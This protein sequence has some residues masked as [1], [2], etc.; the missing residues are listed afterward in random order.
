MSLFWAVLS[1]QCP[2]IELQ[3]RFPV[4]L[5]RVG[6]DFGCSLNEP[7]GMENNGSGNAGREGAGIKLTYAFE[8]RVSVKNIQVAWRNNKQT[9]KI[10]YEI[11][12]K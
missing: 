4:L 11:K 8:G 5:S 10:N 12:D 1:R 7:A 2:E 9:H 3:G 6:L